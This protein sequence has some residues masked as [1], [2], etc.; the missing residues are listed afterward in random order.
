MPDGLVTS[1]KLPS[2]LLCGTVGV[3]LLSSRTLRD[4]SCRADRSRY[5]DETLWKS[6][7]RGEPPFASRSQCWP[8]R[9]TQVSFQAAAFFQACEKIFFIA[10]KNFLTSVLRRSNSAPNA[11]GKTFSE[12]FKF[13]GVN[14]NPA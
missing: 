7:S 10:R 4:E 9:P 11:F 14:L 5:F 2:P 8:E 3:G 12:S 1:W 6:R 13:F